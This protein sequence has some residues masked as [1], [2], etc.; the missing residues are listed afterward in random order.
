MWDNLL[1]I[2]VMIFR[3]MDANNDS[4]EYF[5]KKI[6]LKVCSEDLTTTNFICPKEEIKASEPGPFVKVYF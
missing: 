2:L 4:T 3:K 1:F 6:K 5:Q